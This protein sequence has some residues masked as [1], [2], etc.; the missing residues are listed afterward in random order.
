MRST[1]LLL[2]ATAVFA[3][4]A[5]LTPVWVEVGADHR[6]LARVV[7]EAGGECPAISLDGAAA[8]P[9][10]MRMPVPKQLRP[11]C[12]FEIPKGTKRAAVGSQN[13]VLPVDDPTKVAVIGDTGCRLKGE[14]IQACND[15]DSWPFAKVAALTAKEHPQL[16][17]HVGDYLY[18]EDPCPVADEKKCGGSPSGFTWDAWAAD[19]FT[20]A[21]KLLAAAPWAFSR[22]NH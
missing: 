10:T 14:R 8:V 13:L 20:P 22:G 18:R 9:M 5:T 1:F 2:L 11:A 7:I 6:V 3:T 12:E 4:G 17:I 21:A 16:V 19:F 15:P